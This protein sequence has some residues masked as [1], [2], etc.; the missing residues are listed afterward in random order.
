MTPGWTTA[1]RFAVSI[2]RILSIAVKAIVRPP[3]M[4]VAP[5]DSPDP[6][7]RGTTGTRNSVARRSSSDT[8]AVSV[9]SATAPGRPGVRYAVSS[10]RYDSRSPGSVSSRIPG[11]RD[12]MAWRKGVSM[13]T[14][15]VTAE[16]Y[17]AVIRRRWGSMAAMARPPIV[18]AAL[19]LAVV[20]LLLPAAT[21]AAKA[22]STLRVDA[23]YVSV[24]KLGWTSRAVYVDS[25][26]TVRNRSGAADRPAR[27]QHD[28]RPAWRDLAP[29]GPGRR[30]DRGRHDQRPDD[31]RAAGQVA[32]RRCD[33][34]RPHPLRR[35]ASKQPDR[36]ELAVRQGQR[37]HGPVPLAAVG[38]QA[39]RLRPA[40]PRRPVR[41][42]QQH[43]RAGH[44]RRRSQAGR[45]HDRGSRRVHAGRPVADV[46]GDATCATSR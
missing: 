10:N 29:A 27:V 5:P 43:V 39:R 30:L 31:Q 17:G 37:R 26:A 38:E 45:R 6:A 8:W 18:A 25:K 22:A 36:L 1:T 11:R 2:S 14:V 7:P 24:L 32:R 4:P 16:V 23:T 33:D 19:T 41:D 13:A 34:A 44:G 3:S 20:A 9:G 35:D 12:A 46:P 15:S 21:P 28:R 42:R 40:E